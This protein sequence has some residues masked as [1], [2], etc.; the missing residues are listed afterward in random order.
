[1]KHIYIMRHG[2]TLF[3]VQAR[4]QGWS[5][6]PLTD[7]GKADA[8]LAAEFFASFPVRFDAYFCSTQERASDTL[9]LVFPEIKYKRLK[10]LKEM[11][12]GLFEG[13]PQYLEVQDKRTFFAQFGGETQ[14]ET[15]KRMMSAL[16][17]VLQTNEKLQNIFCVSHGAAMWSLLR[18]VTD[19]T[20]P[21][22]LHNLE[23]LDMLHFTFD[24]AAGSFVFAERIHTL[25]N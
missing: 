15:A 17:E 22:D 9:E 3:N 12:Y 23:N 5:D 11:N 24:E 14:A 21:D 25:S 13:H 16:T 6:S 2:Q 7:K 10:G 19:N 1:M 18:A 20:I 8:K 4:T